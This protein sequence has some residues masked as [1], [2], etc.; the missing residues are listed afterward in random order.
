V[1]IQLREI[2]DKVG[3]SMPCG[4]FDRLYD[5]AAERSPHG[6]VSV[7]SFRGVLEQAQES[8]ID[9]YNDTLGY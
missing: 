6:H 7:E 4:T 8:A 3:V 1:Y 2:F 9:K 5:V